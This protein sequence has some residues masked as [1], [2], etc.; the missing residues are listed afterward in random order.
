MPEQ[1]GQEQELSNPP[2]KRVLAPVIGA[3][4]L[5]MR[6]T[7]TYFEE[8]ARD[9]I[10]E[11]RDAGGSLL[12]LV[13]HFSRWEPLVLA[14]VARRNEPLRHIQYSTGIT[15]R[16]KVTELPIAG[17]VVRHSGAHIVDRAIEQGE[18]TPEQ[19]LARKEANQQTQAVGGRYLAAGMNWLIFPEGGSKKVIKNDDGETVREARE[20][21]VMLPLQRGFVYTL[22]SMTP[23]ERE[24]VKLLGIAMHYGEGLFSS[25]NATVAIPRPESPV[26]GTGEDMFRQGENLLSRAVADAVTQHSLR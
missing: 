21:G 1:P 18:E 8:G 11:H 9:E 19:R 20:P 4:S 23:E 14:Q 16:R 2:D 17:I 6:G 12:L 22:E 10:R 15:A 26:D 3:V 24:R 25:F 7:R 5:L 13:T